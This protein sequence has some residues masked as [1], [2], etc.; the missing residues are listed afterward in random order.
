VNTVRLSARADR[1]NPKISAFGCLVDRVHCSLTVRTNRAGRHSAPPRL[2]GRSDKVRPSMLIV[3][4][5]LQGGPRTP[6]VARGLIETPDPVSV[7][8]RHPARCV[9][10]GSGMQGRTKTSPSSWVGSASSPI[11]DRIRIH[12]HEMTATAAPGRVLADTRRPGPP[13]SRCVES[14]SGGHATRPRSSPGGSAVRVRAGICVPAGSSGSARQS[15]QDV[16][17]TTACPRTGTHRAPGRRRSR[18]RHQVG[19]YNQR[20]RS[21][22][23]SRQVPATHTSLWGWIL[24]LALTC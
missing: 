12:R 10:D 15:V 18:L 11:R 21:C 24:I 17:R 7:L 23:L 1:C 4:T 16:S 2:N 6:P 5:A 3:H 13:R 20:A 19:G 9:P 22:G 8:V 14:V